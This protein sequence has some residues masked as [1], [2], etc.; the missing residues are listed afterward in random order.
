MMVTTSAVSPA[1]D[2]QGWVEKIS[3]F[4]KNTT[5]ECGLEACVNASPKLALTPRMA[6]YCEFL[7]LEVIAF[8]QITH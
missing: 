5:R 7:P 8:N 1:G 6:E 4:A 2:F 3:R